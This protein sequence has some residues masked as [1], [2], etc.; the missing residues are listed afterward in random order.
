M[1]ARLLKDGAAS[2]E[3]LAAIETESEARVEKAIQFARNS[4]DPAPED[5][6]TRVFAA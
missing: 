2:E 3:E 1:R 5:A 4:V 6:L